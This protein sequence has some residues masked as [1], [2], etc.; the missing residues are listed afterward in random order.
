MCAKFHQVVAGF[1]PEGALKDS[2]KSAY[3]GL[4]YNRKHFKENGFRVYYRSGHFE[5][6]FDEGVRFSSYENMSDELK[7]SLRGYLAKHRLKTGE[8]VVDCGA[9]IGEF[10]LYAAKAVGPEGRVVAFEPD[11][12]N[13]DKLMANIRLNALTNVTAVKKGVWS[14]SGVL[15]YVGDSIRGYSFMMSDCAPDAV[16][17]PVT[18]LDEELSSLGIGRV[19]FIKADVEGAEL[20]LIKGAAK[21]LGSGCA[22][23]AVASYHLVDGKKTHEEVEKMLSALGYMTETAHPGHITTYGEKR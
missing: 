4:Y 8:T 10:T 3:F 21:T 9:Y 6:S 13:F 20:E 14:S 12:R 16:D 5:Y 15:K 23:V 11:G 19:D 7:R 18:S 17:V 22:S 1:I 2:L